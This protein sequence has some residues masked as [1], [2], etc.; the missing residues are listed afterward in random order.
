MVLNKVRFILFSILL[1]TIVPFNLFG[2]GANFFGSSIGELDDFYRLNEKWSYDK[3][4]SENLKGNDS[5]E[6]IILEYSW[7]YSWEY[8]FILIDLDKKT[9]K[10][11]SNQKI[12]KRRLKSG[13]ILNLKNKLINLSNQN[14]IYYRSNLVADGTIYLVR[15][16]NN[17]LKNRF[18]LYGDYKSKA[19]DYNKLDFG[20]YRG[21][22][23]IRDDREVNR[24]IIEYMFDLAEKK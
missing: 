13:K 7:T 16:Y 9:I 11:K 14:N 15:Y 6:Y 3:D 17:G 12:L 2:I 10:T 18:G 4:F 5:G 22:D 21:D 23:S 1:F 19:I 20:F 24:E 8:E